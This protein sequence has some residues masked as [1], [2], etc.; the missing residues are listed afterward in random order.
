MAEKLNKKILV[1]DDEP[2]VVTYLTAFFEDNGFDV[3]SAPNGK[4]GF[5][6]AKAEKPD[7]I[8]LDITMPEESGVRCY[9][10]LLDEQSTK[11]IPII[12]VTGVTVEFK[13][14]IE[15]RKQVKAPDAYFEKPIDREKLL[16]EVRRLLG[17]K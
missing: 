11:N 10:E 9:R 7:L 14:F 5:E 8:T 12:I 15:S 1:I 3:I 4:A 16:E 2:D 17:I 13:R 6:K